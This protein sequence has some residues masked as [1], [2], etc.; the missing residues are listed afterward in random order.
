MHSFTLVCYPN[1][2]RYGVPS[3]PLKNAQFRE[4]SRQRL[5]CIQSGACDPTNP[6]MR[7]FDRCVNGTSLCLSSDRVRG[8]EHMVLVVCVTDSWLRY[9]SIRGELHNRGF[10]QITSIGQTHNLIVHELSSRLDLSPTTHTTVLLSHLLQ[11]STS[12]F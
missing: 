8:G 12:W 4:A 9:R 2:D 5:S 10:F 3:D 7:A 6:A 11:C 1:V